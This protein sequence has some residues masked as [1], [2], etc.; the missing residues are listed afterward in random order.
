MAGNKHFRIMTEM[1][2]QE[3]INIGL[4]GGTDSSGGAGVWADVKTIEKLGAS[5]FPVISAI[6][7]Q[8]NPSNFHIIG[9]PHH[10]LKSQLECLLYEELDAIKI[11]MLPDET[12]VEVVSQ[13]ITES[14]CTKIILD[15][16]QKTSSGNFLIKSVAWEK[17]M[18]ELI[19]KVNLITPNLD[20]AKSLT[21][22]LKSSQVELLK[23]CS[24]LGAESVLIKGGHGNG[25]FSVDILWEKSKDVTRFTWDRIPGAT[26]VRGTGCRLASAIAY[27]WAVEK[28]LPSAVKSAGS[29]LQEYIRKLEN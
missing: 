29:F 27:Y 21:G 18:F 9:I 5:P 13:F 3:S 19:P 20:E 15:P 12:S 22:S 23:K 17:L 14:P 2:K 25:D 24:K 7:L 26:S 16:V 6:T 10:G 1:R 8:G 11:G 28:H 4:I